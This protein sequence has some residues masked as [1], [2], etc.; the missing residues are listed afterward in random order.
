LGRVEALSEPVVLQHKEGNIIN[1]VF[2]D[3]RKAEV[4]RPEPRVDFVEN[5]TVVVLVAEDGASNSKWQN[6]PGL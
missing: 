5:V 3:T 4:T 1:I 6:F 2:F